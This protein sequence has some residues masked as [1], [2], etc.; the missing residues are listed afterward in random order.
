MPEEESILKEIFVVFQNKILSNKN[1]K[2][3]QFV[4]FCAAEASKS[5]ANKFVSFLLGVIFDKKQK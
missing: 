2:M 1:T 3:V 5:T 4:A